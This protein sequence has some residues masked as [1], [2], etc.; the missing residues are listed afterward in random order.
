VKWWREPV[1]HFMILGAVI[2]LVD[3]AFS[4]PEDPGVLM[5][6]AVRVALE[7][8]FSRRT[9]RAPDAQERVTL[10]AGWIDE[11]LLFREGRRLG[12]ER[13]D[14]IVRRRVVQ[15]MKALQRT[16]YPVQTPEDDVLRDWMATHSDRYQR[17]ARASFEHVFFSGRH[18]DAKERALRLQGAQSAADPMAGDPFPHGPREAS[19]SVSEVEGQFGGAFSDVV[20]K[21]AVGKSTLAPSEFGWHVVRVSERQQAGS[22]TLDAVREAVEQDWMLAQQRQVEREALLRLREAAGL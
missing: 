4:K 11:E 13:G 12:L 20:F 2:F 1:L 9:G 6:D 22:A 10:E 19:M 5:P 21:A 16:M 7:A 17:P 14:P 8:D 18:A 15:R 3:A